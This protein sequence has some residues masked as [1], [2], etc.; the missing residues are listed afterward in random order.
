[1][2]SFN[3]VTIHSSSLISCYWLW[4]GQDKSCRPWVGCAKIEWHNCLDN[5]TCWRRLSH[6]ITDYLM[7]YFKTSFSKWQR[8]VISSFFA[9][10]LKNPYIL[11][12]LYLNVVLVIS[13]R[14][15]RWS[16]LWYVINCFLEMILS[17]RE[18]GLDPTVAQRIHSMWNRAVSGEE[19]FYYAWR[20]PQM[21][22]N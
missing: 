12:T 14:S 3:D 10:L 15:V 7:S 4:A 13:G 8:W 11:I 22:M 16:R 21:K 9:L 6:L 19:V 20:V 1:M 2:F 17:C 18:S 5:R